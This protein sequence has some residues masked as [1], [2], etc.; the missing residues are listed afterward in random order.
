MVV[1]PGDLLARLYGLYG[2]K[3]LE[4]NIRVFLQA[5][6]DV[7]KGIIKTA[8]EDPNMFFAYN[9]GITATAA[10]VEVNETPDGLIGIKSIT[11][12]QIVNGGQTT[13]SLLYA[14]DN[15]KAELTDTYVQMKLAVFDKSK[16]QEIVPKV[17]EYA[18]TQ[19]RIQKSDLFS[20]HPFNSKMEEI[21]R[22]M[23]TPIQPGQ[24]LTSKW[25]YERVRGQYRLASSKAHNKN[26]FLSEYPKTQVLSKT[27][28]FKFKAASKPEPWLVS[29]GPQKVFVKY[30]KDIISQWNTNEASFDEKYFENSVV[31]AI[32]FKSVD[33]T[34]GRA[35]WYK[36]NRGYKDKIVPYT[37]AKL[38]HFLREQSGTELD[39]D[40]IWKN[41]GLSDD[42]INF[43]NH[44]GRLVADRIKLHEGN[45]G[46]YAKKEECWEAIKRIEMDGDGFDIDTWTVSI[47]GND[48]A[49][50]DFDNLPAVLGTDRTGRT[51]TL[52]KAR[53]GTLYIDYRLNGRRENEVRTLANHEN[54]GIRL[55]D[56]NIRLAEELYEKSPKLL[57]RHPESD[58]EVYYKIGRNGAYWEMGDKSGSIK[59]QHDFRSISLSDVMNFI[60]NP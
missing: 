11:D 47:P 36:E 15:N 35:D 59:D 4:Q 22:V 46:E 5:R 42:Q 21:S 20:T 40:I 28:F 12:L 44:I 32:I 33:S 2:A 9:N 38:I 53:K 55:E 7:N 30:S 6:G 10:N 50:I 13:A 58:L 19:N 23:K 1:V 14:L 52:K 31:E 49:R 51:V 25:F 3:L 29:R 8:T 26:S 34:I 54:F 57:G 24:L 17:A 41:Q 16:L 48:I 45:I 39:Y 37:I 27:D 43:I 56:I 60:D 18:N